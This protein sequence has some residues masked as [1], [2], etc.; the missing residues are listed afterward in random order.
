MATGPRK[1]SIQNIISRVKVIF[2]ESTD[3]Y[4]VNLINDA[5]LDIGKYNVK[6]EFVK[7][8]VI[9]GQRWY[10]L[11]DNSGIEVNKISDVSYMD[12]SGDYMKIP[13]LINYHMIPLTDT[14]ETVDSPSYSSV[15]GYKQPGDYIRWF[16]QHDQLGLI[17][18]RGSDDDKTNQKL[19]DWKSIDESVTN[20]LL[21]HFFAEPD[22]VAI[23]DTFSTTYPDLDN[24][25]HLPIVDYMKKNLFLDRAGVSQDA[26]VG[27]MAMAMSQ[28]HQLKWDDSVRKWMSKRKDKVG[29]PRVLSVPSL[30]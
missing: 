23:T 2:P 10:N 27:Q 17:T 25:L 22:I 20:G 21:L 5:I 24:S 18:S 7:T 9:K 14:D 4:L 8:N 16:V 11:S 6:M 30:I 28:Q 26:N 1:M 19:G 13:R 12:D 15:S 29:G 3:V